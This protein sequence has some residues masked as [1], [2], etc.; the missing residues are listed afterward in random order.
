MVDQRPDLLNLRLKTPSGISLSFT[1]P[2]MLRGLT[3]AFLDDADRKEY[4]QKMGITDAHAIFLVRHLD[5]PIRT[6]TIWSGR[7]GTTGRPF[8][9]ER[10]SDSKP[11][12]P[13]LTEKYGL[14]LAPGK[15][16]RTA[17]AI[18]RTRQDQNTK[19][20]MRSKAVCKCKELERLKQIANKASASVTKYCSNDRKQGCEQP[21]KRFQ[22]S[23]DEDREPGFQLAASRVQPYSTGIRHR[24]TLLGNLDGSRG[25]ARR[26]LRCSVAWAAVREEPSS[27]NLGRLG[28]SASSQF[29]IRMSARAVHRAVGGRRKPRRNISLNYSAA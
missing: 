27:V 4:M 24:T 14:Y 10:T 5:Q 28:Y 29:A 7:S 16:R 21:E 13:E 8:R 15:G 19:S 6:A 11:A 25:T 20:T 26:L 23:S 22:D 12:L 18:A 1:L 9:T 2:R 17:G 3:D